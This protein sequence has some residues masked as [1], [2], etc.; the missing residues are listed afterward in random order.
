MAHKKGSS[1]RTRPKK[2]GR[3]RR[4]DE[5]QLKADV[6]RLYSTGEFTLEQIAE[7]L[8]IAKITAWRYY[9][10]ALEEEWAE[11]SPKAEIMRNEQ[12]DK[13][14]RTQ[15]LC[16]AMLSPKITVTKEDPDRGTVELADFLKMEKMAQRI[17]TL[18]ER[19]AKMNG[20]DKPVEVNVNA[21]ALTL[22]QFALA[23]EKL[24]GG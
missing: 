13:L 14:L 10:R 12:T 19:L 17:V 24:A 16:M 2:V 9:N 11:I 23:A 18:S 21:G 4:P 15:N 8:G 20:L 5:Q 3:P 7:K 22:E 6:V 1:G